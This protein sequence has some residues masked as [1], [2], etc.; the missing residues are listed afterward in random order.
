[1]DFKKDK[2]GSSFSLVNS[3]GLPSVG[4]HG[5]SSGCNLGPSLSSSFGFKGPGLVQPSSTVYGPTFQL[6]HSQV[7]ST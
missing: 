4:F 5:L 7:S 3:K 2:T 6:A 1:M